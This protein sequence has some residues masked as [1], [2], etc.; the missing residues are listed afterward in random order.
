MRAAFEGGVPAGTLQRHWRAEHRTDYDGTG[1]TLYAYLCIGVAG[2]I[3]ETGLSRRNLPRDFRGL[4]GGLHR[5]ICRLE[6]CELKREVAQ[7]PV[8]VQVLGLHLIQ[9]PGLGHRDGGAGSRNY[10][11]KQESTRS[12]R[13]HGEVGIALKGDIGVLHCRAVGSKHAARYGISRQLVEYDVGRHVL[14][15][16]SHLHLRIL[17]IAEHR[18]CQR[19]GVVGNEIERIRAVLG[20]SGHRMYLLNRDLGAGNRLIVRILHFTRNGSAR[21]LHHK[22]YITVA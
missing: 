2:V 15:G 20:R 1:L 5:Y 10:G 17:L 9:M 13:L 16:H 11:F 4:V 6:V 3:S 18:G 21:R 7:V 22:A 12:I 19:I 8:L 14:V